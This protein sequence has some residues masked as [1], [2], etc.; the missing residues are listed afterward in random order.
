MRKTIFSALFGTS[1]S[2]LLFHMGYGFD[3]WEYWAAML[4]A[5]GYG[6]S[7]GTGS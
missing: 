5:A 1:L 7:M 2:G 3:T 6:F 4:L